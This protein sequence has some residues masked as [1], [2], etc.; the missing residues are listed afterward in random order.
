MSDTTTPTHAEIE[1]VTEPTKYD[2]SIHSNPDAAAWA[3]FFKA[4][5]PDSDEGL[6]HGWFANA[7]MAMHDHMQAERDE[8]AQVTVREAIRSI[9][10]NL[11]SSYTARNGRKIS[12]EGDDGEKCWIL[13]NDGYEALCAIAGGGDE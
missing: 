7:M 6:M 5:F 12:I 10:G 1:A 3:A 13:D 2:M 9:I 11:S 8:P 4:T